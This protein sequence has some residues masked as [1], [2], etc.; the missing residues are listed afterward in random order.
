MAWVR[1]HEDLTDNPKVLAL[2]DAL[3]RFFILAL[4][5]GKKWGGR[6]PDLE[7]AAMKF[8]MPVTRMVVNFEKLIIARPGSDFGLMEKGPDGVY[9]LHD[10]DDWQYQLSSETL[11][12]EALSQ[13][14]RARR[15]RERKRNG[16]V[17]FRHENVTEPRDEN[18][19]ERHESS[20]DE[21]HENV[22]AESDDSSRFVTSRFERGVGGRD[23]VSVSV[24]EEVKA[25]IMQTASRRMTYDS[26]PGWQWFYKHYPKDKINPDMD[27]RLWLSI[28]TSVEIEEEIRSKLPRF[29]E[30][31]SWMK[32][33]GAF[34]PLAETFLSKRKFRMEPG[35]PPKDS[36]SAWETL[37]ERHVSDH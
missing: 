14:E 20:R 17:T 11:P 25:T 27:L 10:W 15:Y 26:L 29:L 5:I 32:E 21:R 13:A 31:A 24:S 19:T 12:Q 1:L 36:R 8:R 35:G 4:C 37:G 33:N 9:Q 28:V 23:S 34:I 7:G 18:V 2:S 3:F 6:F 30:S 16:S 22:T